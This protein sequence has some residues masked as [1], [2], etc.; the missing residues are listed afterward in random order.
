MEV[1][2]D[3]KVR[4]SNLAGTKDLARSD[5]GVVLRMAEVVSVTHIRTYF[6]C[7][8]FGCIRSVFSACVAVEPGEVGKGKRLGVWAGRVGDLR[9]CFAEVG[10]WNRCLCRR[11]VMSLWRRR[12]GQ[13]QLCQLGLDLLQLVLQLLDLFILSRRRL[14]IFH[15]CLQVGRGSL[16]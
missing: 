14:S 9:F 15:S 13:L 8:E 4:Q 6:R 1:A 2:A 12:V 10:C 11:G 16:T 3:S 5:D 7:E